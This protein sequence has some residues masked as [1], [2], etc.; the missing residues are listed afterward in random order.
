MMGMRSRQRSIP[1]G[2]NAALCGRATEL[3]PISSASWPSSSELHAAI[4][5][6]RRQ[7]NVRLYPNARDMQANRVCS[8][9]RLVR[10]CAAAAETWPLTATK[11]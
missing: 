4:D 8:R 9:R 5:R 6:R 3:T 10:S 2:T 11:Q 1:C 7:L